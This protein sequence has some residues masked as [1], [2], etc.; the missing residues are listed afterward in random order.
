[1]I[2]W[3][4]DFEYIHELKAD[5]PP[6]DFDQ[7]MFKSGYDIGIKS[8]QTQLSAKEAD[9]QSMIIERDSLLS[10][11]ADKN[12]KLAEA[13]AENRVLLKML[14]TLKDSFPEVNEAFRR[15]TQN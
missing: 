12:K 2:Q 13:R 11:V 15:L 1:M 7:K 3:K 14:K 6:N 8:I 5:F 9:L 4:K 10:R